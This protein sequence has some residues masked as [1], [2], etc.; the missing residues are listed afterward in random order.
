MEQ[1]KLSTAFFNT[2]LQGRDMDQ[3]NSDLQK[4]ENHVNTQFATHIPFS[5]LVH[6]TPFHIYVLTIAEAV[7]K[8]T[9][10]SLKASFGSQYQQDIHHTTGIP[11]LYV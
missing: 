7:V 9:V 2:M 1:S 4:T 6:E 5:S 10:L 3:L 11:Q 8:H